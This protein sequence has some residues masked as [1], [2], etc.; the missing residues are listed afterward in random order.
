MNLVPMPA[1]ERLAE[2]KSGFVFYAVYSNGDFEIEF[3]TIEEARNYVKDLVRGTAE[4]YNTTIR[5]ARESLGLTIEK[6]EY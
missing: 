5:K 6:I 3:P 1:A 4:H 2:L